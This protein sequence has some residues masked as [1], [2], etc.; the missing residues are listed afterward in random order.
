MLKKIIAAGAV[1][2]L[3]ACTG[4]DNFDLEEVA[5]ISSSSEVTSSSSDGT[6]NSS[7]SQGDIVDS[8]SSQDDGVSSSSSD[9]GPQAQS[10]SI[11]TF[12]KGDTS[13][14]FGNKNI[15]P[16]GFTL[17]EGKNEDLT[18]FWDMTMLPD[19]VDVAGDSIPKC[20]V[21]K[22]QSKPKNCELLELKAAGAI[23]QNTITNQ[24][25]DLHYDIVVKE[26]IDDFNSRGGLINYNV[27]ASGDQAALGL[28][29]GFEADEGKT[30]GELGITKL[31]GIHSF[32]YSY[33]GGAH[34]FRAVSSNEKDFW[35]YKV[36]ASEAAF[37]AIEIPLTELEPM[38]SFAG[39]EGSEGSGEGEDAIPGF[40]A[41]PAV[42]FDLSKVAK[43]LWVVEYD[44]QTPA[45]NQ[46]SLWVSYFKAFKMPE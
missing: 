10:I 32:G 40:P 5:D 28:N 20:P 46:G 14:V 44:S 1:C 30:I 6:A 45:N 9:P 26:N 19:T 7:S 25:A 24:Y 36:P 3:F 22:Q 18:Q 11:A 33:K 15:S 13:P 17:K 41:T 31:D 38:G 8:S 21:I 2:V 43:F 42:P 27:K 12:D 29:V 37:S 35:E 16:Y 23:L 39:S 4:K 34:K